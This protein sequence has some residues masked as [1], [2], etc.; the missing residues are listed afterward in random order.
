MPLPLVVVEA[1]AQDR[2]APETA[3][4]IEACTAGLAVGRCALAQVRDLEPVSAIAI[5]S[6]RDREQLNALVEVARARRTTEAWRSEELTFKPEDQ[7]VER[8]RT[9]GLTIAALYRGTLPDSASSETGKSDSAARPQEE[10]AA[11]HTTAPHNGPKQIERPHETPARQ[12]RAEAHSLTLTRSA[13]AWL[14]AGA[15][16]YYD[17]E[18][19]AWRAG[20]R[21]TG[22]I[23]A[24]HFPLFLSVVGSY[25][26]G[27]R[28][29]GVSLSWSTV[30]LGPGVR[31]PL[32]PSLELSGI[33]HGLLVN[34]SGQASQAGRTSQ[35]S[36]WVPGANLAVALGFRASGAL[37]ISLAVEAQ[38][39]AGRVSI[40][41]HD[42][43]VG[44][45]GKTAL[46][47]EIQLAMRL[48]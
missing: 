4:L 36:V 24:R 3:A 48:F 27:L 28:S 22:T 11:A 43:A 10:R 26:V 18:L 8:F 47:A 2:T 15:I 29:T 12:Q 37:R 9:L 31:L 25:A 40:R 16:A 42:E 14:G 41:E 33:A 7:R 21:V 45:V 6:W 13:E 5:L 46:G 23:G 19:A 1:P 34:V 39:L 32:S 44:V 30:G 35:Q 17:R 20:G 38:Q